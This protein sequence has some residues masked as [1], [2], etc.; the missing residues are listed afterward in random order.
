MHQ[1]GAFLQ[2]LVDMVHFGK[3]GSP[4][5]TPSPPPP[6]AQA[7]PW[8]GGDTEPK[9]LRSSDAHSSLLNTQTGAYTHAPKTTG[10]W[11]F[12][13]AALVNKACPLVVSSAPPVRLHGPRW[14]PGRPAGP[15]GAPPKRPHCAPS[16]PKVGVVPRPAPSAGLHRLQDEPV[17][18]GPP[19][20]MQLGRAGAGPMD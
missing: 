6:S 14:C 17:V 1:C 19:C 11:G 8:G 12:W 9:W 5:W 20:D 15:S 18:R 13:W 7:T 16:R 2:F 4:P 3:G 10:P